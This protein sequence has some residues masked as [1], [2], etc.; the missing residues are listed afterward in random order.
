MKKF[1]PLWLLL[2]C[3]FVLL[4]QI[5]GTVYRDYNGNGSRQSLAPMI[6]PGVSGIIVNAYDGGNSL[7]SSTTSAGDGTYSMPFT[8]PVRIEFV[9]P[10][11]SQCVHPA[12]D[13]SGVGS[14]GNNI[15]MVTGSTANLNY[16]VQHPDDY[17]ASTNPDIFIP[18]YVDGNPLGG[19]TAGTSSGFKSYTYT[20]TGTGT[21]PRNLNLSNIGSVYGVAYSKQAKRIFA[22]AFLKRHVGLGPMGSGGIYLLEPT[23]SSFNVT[24][25]YDMDA[26]GHRTR[27][28]AGAP[29]YGTGTSFNLVGSPATSATYLGSNDVLTGKPEG[30][31]VIGDNGPTGRGLSAAAGTDANDPGAFDQVCKVGLGDIEISEDGKFLFVMN[32]YSR[33]LFRLELNDAYAP[34]SVI[35]V[36]SYDL[37][38]VS[39]TNGVLRPFGL[40]YNRGKLYVGAVASGEDGGTNVVGGATDLYAYVFE[41]NDPAGA[42]N[43]SVSPVLT[44]PLNYLKGGAIQTGIQGRQWYPWSA[45]TTNLFTINGEQTYPTPVLSDIDFTDRGDMIVDFLDRSG[46]Q[47]GYNNYRNLSGTVSG[48]S[49][50]VGGDILVAGK[51]CGTGTF[52]LESNGSYTSADGSIYS[53]GVASTQGPGGGEFFNKDSFPVWHNE[54]SMGSAAVLRGS[55]NVL[56]T[57]MDPI[58]DFSNGTAKFSINNGARTG[59]YQIARNLTGGFGKANGLG[60]VELAGDEPPIEIGNMVWLDTDKDGIQDPGENGIANVSLELFCDDDNNGIPDGAAIATTSTDGQGYWYFNESN[61]TDGDCGLAGNQIGPQP[62]KNYLVRIAA[63]DWTGGLGVNDLNLL[64]LSLPNMPVIGI[65]D[66]SDND[67]TLV[68]STPQIQVST[69]KWGENNHSFDFGFKACS[70]DAGLDLALNCTTPSGTIGTPSIPGEVYSWSPATGLSNPSVAQPVASPSST[71]IYTLTVNGLCTD[72][73]TVTVDN[74]PPSVNIAGTLSVCNGST[75][76]LTANGGLSWAWNP[77]NETTQQ[78]TASAGNYTVTATGANGCTATSSVTV[79]NIQGTVGNYIWTDLNGNGQNDEPASAG[80]NGVTVE[81]WKETAPGSNVYLLDQTVLSANNGADPGYYQFIIC[82]SANYKVKFPTSSGGFGLAT[83]NPNPGVDNNSDADPNDGFS[84][85]FSIDV[86]GSGLAKDNNTIDAAFYKPAQL[87]NFVWNDLNKNGIQDAGEVG[88]AGIS[89]TLFNSGNSIVG[90][91]VT[92]AY[93]YYH[94]GNLTPGSYYLSFTPPANYVFSPANQGANDELDNDVNPLSGLTGTYV[95]AVGDSNMTVDAGIFFQQPSTASVGNFVWFDTNQDGIQDNGEQGISGVTVTLYNNVG[96]VV[97][98]TITDANGFY[99]FTQVLPGTYTIGFTP[100][101]GLT[102]S[103]NNGGVSNPSN[104]DANPGSGITSSFTVLAGNEITYID[105]GLYSL[106]NTLGGLGDRVWFDLDQDGIQ[107]AGEPGVVGVT[108]T[109]YQADGITVISTT[110]TNAYGNYIFNNLNAGQYIVGFSNLPASYVFTA[111]GA[112][113]SSTNSDANTITGKTPLIS[114]AAGQFNL[115]FDAGIHTNNPANTNSIGDFVWLDAN[116]NGI[117]DPGEPAVSGVTVTLYDNSNAVL[118]IS[119]TD[120][121]GHYLFPDLPNGTYYVGFSNLPS[122]FAF[123]MAGQ[124]TAATD[125]DPNPSSGLTAP[126]T[127]TGNTHIT[128]VDAGLVQVANLIGLGTLGDRVW[129]DTDGNGIQDAGELGV[130]GVTVTLYAQNGTTILATTTTN[131]QGNY[132]FTGLSAGTFVVGFSDLPLGFTISPKNADSQGL[133]G[134]SNSDVNS[135]TQKTDQVVLGMGE[136]KMSVDMGIVPPAG[137]ASLG[138]FVWFDLNSD[139]LQSPGEPGVT[140]V[141]VTLFDNSQNV[142]KTTSTDANGLYGFTGLIPGTY[143]VGF[144]N[145]PAGYNLTMFNADALGINGSQNSDANT[146]TGLTASV[147]LAAG[148]HNPNLD[149]GVVSTTVAALGDFVWFDTNQNGIQDPGEHGVG[150]VLVTLYDNL[151]NPVSSMIT[152]PSGYYL[153]TN[154][155]PGTYTLGFS[156]IPEGMVF[157]QQTG[158]PSDGDNSNANPVNGMTAPITVLPGTYNPTID[159]GLTT[160]NSAGLGNL[161]WHDVNENGLQ[162]VGEPG[163]AGILVTLYAA[164]GTTILATA[165][166][167]GEGDY[168]FRNLPAGTYI[169]GFSNLPSGSTRTQVVGVL[170]DVLNSDLNLGGKTN[171]ITLIAG[172]FNPNIDAGI[173]YGFPVSAADLVATMAVLEDESHCRVYWFTAEEEYTTNFEIERSV[174]GTDFSRVGTLAA[175]GHTNG[176]K[177]YHLLDDVHAVNDAK[178]LYYRIKL[179]DLDGAVRISNVVTVRPTGQQGAVVI[180]PS[181]FQHQLTVL[182]TATEDTEV[183]MVLTDVAGRVIRRS[184]HELKKGPNTLQ[185]SDLSELP[186]ANYFLRLQDR[187]SGEMHIRKVLK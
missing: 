109:L 97:G 66:A 180:Y 124:G 158:G 85:A 114:L 29:A 121:S 47:Y 63:T 115:T 51:N 16:G 176:R 131:A 170:N 174:N 46:H 68:S 44:F 154:V 119:F 71:T 72:E 78:I 27:A 80:I 3:P 112:V 61:V 163:V 141:M 86:N 49:Y 92:D 147:T 21:S 26:N 182:Y 43:F 54:T 126:V 87:G 130:A 14:D 94:F 167:D 74:T 84:P 64:V 41:L 37:P 35:G 65:P 165:V 100:P 152:S 69:G 125:S 144:S 98:T 102:F 138:D 39:V 139:G 56:V 101:A 19:G 62:S 90:S 67:A 88:V 145:L 53:G 99:L 116:A 91:T 108:V 110:T 107:D 129:Y 169:V 96:S 173:Y 118:A 76:T 149:A 55:S 159:A 20:T 42:A 40:G 186:A 106:P 10:A 73:V 25:F 82:N 48:G 175:S 185:I 148:N 177:E 11:G 50:D 150:G 13:F 160:P 34:T 132:I 146:I 187:Q 93:G 122:G 140:G 184:L 166:T 59:E 168:S 79:S 128:D 105:A 70:A 171:A 83:Q 89:V 57:L 117:Q 31:G 123:T 36:Q 135:A 137:T 178:L 32:L 120:A 181:P 95:L 111:T 133:N 5:S 17:V 8:V 136:D 172:E 6:E 77:N 161:V 30:L 33:K 60:D 153:F 157:T 103:P 23:V 38:S 9:I 15:R 156:N 151:N 104:S 155:L 81:L 75:T 142:L 113:D 45:S 24:Q 134:E 2:C 4:A 58:N 162:D 164:D 12:M 28:G 7:V 127:L 52:T 22:S 143:H 179:F 18:L 1:L 183:E